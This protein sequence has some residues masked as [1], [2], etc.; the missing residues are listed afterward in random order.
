MGATTFQTEGKGTTVEDAFLAAREH[1]AY[2]HGHGGYT[3]TLAEKDSYY[4]AQ[5]PEGVTVAEFIRALM[6]SGDRFERGEFVKGDRPKWAPPE[7]D[8]LAQAYDD[9][10]GPC[11]AVKVAPGK[12]VF[13]GWASC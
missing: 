9:K 2:L 4:E 1:E 5:L 8:A 11:V 3:G 10:W 12:W 7:W 6:D 13:V